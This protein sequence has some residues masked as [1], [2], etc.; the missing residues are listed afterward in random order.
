[1]SAGALGH[2]HGP[3]HRH[4]PA[5]DETLLAERLVL[6]PLFD[7]LSRIL[8]Q[9]AGLLMLAAA[10][11]GPERLASHVASLKD[12]L[13]AAREG[14]AGS[15]APSR[16]PAGFAA[17]GS[18]LAELEE[19]A[20]QLGSRPA[21]MLGDD[22]AFVDALGRLAGIRGR[23]LAASAPGLGIGLVDFAGACC[24]WGR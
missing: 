5:G 4:P 23:L 20:A 2:R 24:A 7:R 8:G 10:G 11:L 19:L 18:A 13:A 1:V 17:A 12:Q 22:R 15:N 3:D 16:L 21:G 6:A 14:F 9:M